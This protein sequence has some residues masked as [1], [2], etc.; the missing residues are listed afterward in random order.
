MSGFKI[1]LGVKV[2]DSITG[3]KGIV[4]ARAEYITGC[5]QYSL[6]PKAE[7]NKAATAAW[8]DEDRL[9]D[10][11][12]KKAAKVPKGGPQQFAAPLK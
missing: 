11:V 3:F 2:K 5:K 8:F 6:V 4:T 9:V 12:K 7:K 10:S 1:E